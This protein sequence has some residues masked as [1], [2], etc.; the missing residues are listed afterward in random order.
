[1]KWDKWIVIGGSAL[2]IL[3]NSLA[4]VKEFFFVPV[5]SLAL[6][7]IYLMVFRVDVLMYLMAFS[8]PFSIVIQSDK[9][10]LGL[11]VPTEV[12]MIAVTLLFLCRVFY[13]LSLNRKILK[14][15][16][17]NKK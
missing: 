5:I 9:I 15:G 7:L 16:L 14:V 10:N 6:I 3:I 17:F 4:I 13:D 8:T 12:I 1:M 11:S 2:M